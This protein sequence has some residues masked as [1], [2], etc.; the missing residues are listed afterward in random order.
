M[1]AFNSGKRSR[2]GAIPN[3][4][5]SLYHDFHHPAEANF[6]SAADTRPSP[7]SAWQATVTTS[8]DVRRG[9]MR[10]PGRSFRRATVRTA[11]NQTRARCNSRC[12]PRRARRL[13]SICANNF[14]GREV[15]NDQ[16]IA[17]VI[18]GIDIEAGEMRLPQALVQFQVENLKP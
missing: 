3:V 4:E 12:S 5:V 11:R 9:R 7:A 15:F 1:P 17:S 18:K 6:A 8:R 10:G 2:D 14:A 13:Q 16:V